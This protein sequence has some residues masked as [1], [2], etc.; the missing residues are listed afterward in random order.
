MKARAEARR[1]AAVDLGTNTILLLVADIETDGS[2][3]VLED[4]ARITR[5]GEGVDRNGALSEA[6]QERSLQALRHYAEECRR[7]AVDEVAVVG[8][9]ALRDAVN[10]DAFIDRVARDLGWK[11]RVL[12]AEEEARYSFI[13][14][15]A[16]LDLRGQEVLAVDVGGGSTE[17]I[18][19]RD[20]V[21]SAW[22]T[23]QLGSV[24]LTERYLVADP[25]RAEEC[26][27]VIAAVDRELEL[28][29]A[30]L[31]DAHRPQSAVG[32]AGTFTTLSALAQGLRTYSHS[33]VHGAVLTLAEVERLI[34]LF[35]GRS[36]AER[37]A[38]P[39]LEPGRADVILAGSLLVER[40]MRFFRFD[41]ILI[42]DQ[43]VRYGILYE[44]LGR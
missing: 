20:G 29:C 37:R 44:R 22:V 32:I 1:F 12:S 17:L 34:E 25:P 15:C 43:G 33:D 40:V 21:P 14:V 4:A 35:Q 41:R 38:I 39:G 19:G 5:L 16:G 23:T 7:L 11:L 13:A 18:W 24:R 31:R 42:S 2:F 30:A 8:T 10:R 6:A 26:R 28:R 9:S 3:V 36:A 27:E